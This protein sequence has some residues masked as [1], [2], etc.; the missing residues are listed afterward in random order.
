[1][2]HAELFHY[3]TR[4]QVRWD[5]EG[6]EFFKLKNLKSIINHCTCAFGRQTPSPQLRRNSPP[7]LHTRRESRLERRDTQ[8]DK[9][10]ECA[11][12]SKFDRERAESMLA[13]MRFDSLDERIAL[14]PR[15][16]GG[17]KLHDAR[18]GV[19]VGKGFA[20]RVAPPAK[21]EAFGLEDIPGIHS[22]HTRVVGLSSDSKT[23]TKCEP[24]RD[25]NLSL[26]RIA[27]R[28]ACRLSSVK[29]KDAAC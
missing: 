16:R 19:H 7:R 12:A 23:N 1:M 24:E 27:Q 6:N 26:G 17:E 11:G 21:D 4:A 18:V 25:G 20:V 14:L 3:A 22:G 10:G 15:Q 5:G 8:P 2:R 28:V 13:K 29:T 9:S